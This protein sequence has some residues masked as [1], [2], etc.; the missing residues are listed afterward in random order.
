MKVVVHDGIGVWLAARRLNIGKF[1]WPRDAAPTMPLTRAP[2]RARTRPAVEE[3]RREWSHHA[4]V[5]PLAMLPMRGNAAGCTMQSCDP[6][7]S[8]PLL[9]EQ[10]AV[11]GS[12]S[13]HAGR[14]GLQA[15]NH[16]QDDA[17][18]SDHQAVDV[19]GEVRGYTVDQRTFFDDTC[20]AD[21]TALALE[22]AREAPA[23]TVEGE[24]QKPKRAPLPA[25][26]PRRE[27]RH[28]PHTSTCRCGCGCGCAMKRIG[29]DASEK[30]DYVPG[31]F[32]V[33]RHIGGKRVCTRCATLVQEPVAPHIID[34]GLPDD[35]P[36]R[37]GAGGQ[38][39]RP[40]AAVS[41][42]SGLRACG[43]GD[44]AL[45]AGAVGRRVRRATATARG[46]ADDRNPEGAVLHADETP[47][48]TL[49]PG[50]GKTDKAY[51]W[52]WCTTQFHT[53]GGAAAG[54]C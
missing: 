44:R 48:P 13:P 51:M 22:M 41:S 6:R 3:R 10:R 17:R 33:E 40:L 20:E 11:A 27:I 47:V 12:R 4:A 1:V 14:V 28:E 24:T 9:A 45:D 23:K 42:G 46:R 25:H 31:V 54:S 35:G 21:L 43:H 36:P 37:A 38:I 7:A 39:P 30:L 49:K 8:R 16:R 29:G 32:T 19:R 2:R 50:K 53:A 18:A 5:A 34:K 52:T 26:L 15:G